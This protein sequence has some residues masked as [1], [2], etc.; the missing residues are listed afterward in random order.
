MEENQI[1][2]CHSDLRL[3]S[4]PMKCYR[5]WWLTVTR[6][7]G[8]RVLVSPCSI[9]FWKVASFS[10]TS[11]NR[12]FVFKTIN[13]TNISY[14]RK[15]IT[16][17][18]LHVQSN[19]NYNQN[20]T[21]IKWQ[22][23]SNWNYNQTATTIKLQLPSNCNLERV[24]SSL[25]WD[26]YCDGWTYIQTLSHLCRLITFWNGPDCWLAFHEP[27]VEVLYFTHTLVP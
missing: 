26:C 24:V 8:P 5:E 27:L 2:H 6:I 11:R 4:K 14:Q 12:A 20:A 15:D 23:Q 17:L 13:I 16:T 3:G 19:C 1:L 18:Q 7:Q 22:L 10:T 21:T 9:S 25:T